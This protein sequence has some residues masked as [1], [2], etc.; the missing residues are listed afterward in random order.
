[1]LQFNG[2]L[3]L[4]PKVERLT[5]GAEQLGGQGV[6]LLRNAITEGS[7]PA[8]Q[9]IEVLNGHM[10][11]DELREAAAFAKQKVTDGQIKTAPHK[12]QQRQA[13]RRWSSAPVYAGVLEEVD[14]IS[15]IGPGRVSHRLSASGQRDNKPRRPWWWQDWQL[16]WPKLRGS[17][18]RLEELLPEGGLISIDSAA[19]PKKKSK[20]PQNKTSHVVEVSMAS[21]ADFAGGLRGRPSLFGEVE[22]A[23]TRLS[24]PRR[25]SLSEDLDGRKTVPLKMDTV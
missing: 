19:Q 25:A 3:R 21:S 10:V 23:P 22:A 5:V 13:S 24:M 7:I 17:R 16:P 4:R 18:R 2:W 12:Q 11:S 1:L 9:G 6:A 14:V 8:L 20:E 15:M